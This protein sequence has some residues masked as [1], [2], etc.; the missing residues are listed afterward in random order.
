MYETHVDTIE[1]C[2]VIKHVFADRAG[3]A[4]VIVGLDKESMDLDIPELIECQNGKIRAAGTIET[5]MDDAKIKMNGYFHVNKK[6][7]MQFQV[8]SSTVE[9]PVDEQG[10][11][12]FLY[13]FID[14]IGQTL[15]KRIANQFGNETYDVIRN[16]PEKLT[17]IKGINKEKALKI[18][19]SYLNNKAYEEIVGYFHGAITRNQAIKI[20]ERYGNAYLNVF[21]KN[22]YQLI[23]DLNGF[24][25]KTVDKLALASG[26]PKD[27]PFRIE[28]AII[29]ILRKNE[30]GGHCYCHIEVFEELAKDFL[31]EQDIDIRQVAKVLANQA[32][33][34]HLVIE[35]GRIYRTPV[36][37]AEVTIAKTIH[38]L[39]KSKKPC[40][41]LK[42][43]YE[44]IEKFDLPQMPMDEIQKSG[45][46]MAL[47]SS[48]SVISGGPGRGK[49]TELNRICQIWRYYREKPQYQ[50][51]LGDIILLAPTGRAA[52]R[53]GE[54]TSMK[55]K[56]IHR[57]LM[58]NRETKKINGNEL[59]IL[60]ECSMCDVLLLAQ[61]FNEVQVS[62]CVLVGD[63]NQLPSVGPGK[64]FWDIINSK[65]VPVTQ[66][67]ICY[68]FSGAIEKN[69]ELILS[70]K[71]AKALVNEKDCSLH[72]FHDTEKI[73]E[74][75]LESYLKRVNQYGL[76]ETLCIVANRKSSGGPLAAETL[77]KDLQAALNPYGA[78]IERSGFRVGDR[79]MHIRN[80]YYKECFDCFGILNEGVFNGDMGVIIEDHP[81]DKKVVVEFDDKRWTEYKYHE[82]NTLI[83]AYAMSIHKSQGGE[84]DAVLMAISNREIYNT[85][86]NLLYTGATRAKKHFDLIGSEKA[87]NIGIKKIESVNRNTTL[88]DRLVD[89]CM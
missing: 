14:G 52:K 12:A 65:I 44:A 15:A 80:D 21:R 73:K 27:S 67:K 76:R 78:Q 83:L 85:N 30:E 33:S 55:A 8:V 20:R 56:T 51:M 35:N 77:N 63:V 6:Y 54:S 72:F 9:L 86:R 13:R 59:F 68:R 48:I 81:L 29:E 28:A 74:C 18:S 37:E 88:M 23:V 45:V 7:G 26:M 43:V 70:G 71:P 69:S 32:K 2:G 64:V 79:V 39:M 3:W 5:P 42:D 49:T 50:N 34:H 57:F 87:I 61:L 36:Y 46:V 82:F 41:K 11:T 10:I 53:L 58:T 31:Q 40:M 24:A 25:F 89:S 62:H 1:L 38:R 22:I 66:L 16:Q 75:L 4:S 60:D 47:R 17:L 84:A 19:D